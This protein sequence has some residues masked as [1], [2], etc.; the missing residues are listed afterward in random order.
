[1]YKAAAKKGGAHCVTHLS[2]TVINVIAVI[3]FMKNRALSAYGN[4]AMAQ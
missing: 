4:K 3:V 2:K 1:M